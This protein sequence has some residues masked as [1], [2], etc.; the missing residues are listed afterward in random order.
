KAFNNSAITHMDVWFLKRVSG[1]TKDFDSAQILVSGRKLSISKAEDVS[2]TFNTGNYDEGCIRFDNNGSTT[3]G[4]QADLYFGDV[5]VKKG[6]SNNGWSPSQAELASSQDLKAAQSEIKMT[7]DLISM[8]LS[9]LDDS[10]VKSA[11]LTINA[12][13]IIMK[14][15]KSTTDVANAIGAYFAV[16]QNAINLF[17]DKINVKANMIVDGAV[18]S[19]KIASKSINTAHLNG[20]II[21]AD[22]I[23]SNAITADAIKAGAVTTDKMTA[24]SINGDRITAGTLDAAKIKAGSIT[25]S[26]IA[27]GTITSNQIKAG[28]ISAANIATG[29]ITADKIAANAI[30]VSK[31]TGDTANFVKAGFK[32]LY[33][34]LDITGERFKFTGSVNNESFEISNTNYLLKLNYNGNYAGINPLSY[35]G[36]SIDIGSAALFSIRC[37]RRT[38]SSENILLELD[39]SHARIGTQKSYINITDQKISIVKNNQV[40]QK[41]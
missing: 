37:V 40:V 6:K 10:T 4:T 39:R 21:T 13:G 15:G 36:I 5:S 17:S 19:A 32:S 31:I 30:D 9:A 11:S 29:A 41:Y 1:S 16:N 25:A 14:A 3:V 33:S 12:D 26:Q 2:V 34:N 35:G 38:D 23:S 7:T 18:T 28:G 24:N 8:N 22:V 20:K 27:S